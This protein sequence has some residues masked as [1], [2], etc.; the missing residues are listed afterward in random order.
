MKA[1]Y[2]ATIAVACVLVAC[3]PVAYVAGRSSAAAAAKGVN[4]AEPLAAK[5]T[6]VMPTVAAKRAT[7]VR[8]A[9]AA[10]VARAQTKRATVRHNADEVVLPYR[11]ATKYQTPRYYQENRGTCWDFATVGVLEQSYRQNGVEKGFMKAE[12]YLRM[13]EQAYGLSMI[14]ACKNHPD[15][16][17]VVGDFVYANSTEG[18]EVWWLYNLKELYNKLLPSSVCPY[19][20][21]EHEHECPGMEKALATNPIKFNVKSMSTAYNAMETKRLMV[22]KDRPLAWSSEMHN[23]VYFFPCTDPYWKG[24]VECS[25]RLAVQCPTDRYYGSATCARV[26]SSMFNMDGEFFIHGQTIGEGGHAMN[27]VGY[28]DE[29]TT[30]QGQTGGFIIRNSWHDL[31]Y[32]TNPN[33]RGARGSHSMAYWMQEISAWDEKAV[34]PGPLNPENWISCVEQEVGPHHRIGNTAGAA[35]LRNGDEYDISQTCLSKKFME[36][37]LS[38]SLQPTEFVCLDNTV[39]DTDKRF[40][41]FLINYERSVEQDLAKV[42]MLRYDSVSHEQDVYCTP[43]H[44]PAQIAYWFRPIDEQLEVLKDDEDLCGF[45]FWPYDMLNKQVGMY[46][47]FYTTY[48]DIEWDDQSY[49]ANQ[50]QHP[51]LDYSFIKSSTGIQKTMDFDGPS[52]FPKGR[53]D[54]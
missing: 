27:V 15:V 26:L 32:G 50:A 18:G 23:T 44:I 16:C 42:C 22:E 52:P 41:Y 10:R 6:V 14:E 12:E 13:N 40:R 34:C 54:D 48:F 5:K 31:T 33:G 47:N 39:C 9:R 30:K 46:N 2:I 17:D 25:S 19:T 21:P 11:Y 43:F 45:W 53:Y 3:V 4:V 36:N 49:L 37:L 29:F 20:E 35:P 38:V 8:A 51:D 7:G 28:N 24:R 1:A